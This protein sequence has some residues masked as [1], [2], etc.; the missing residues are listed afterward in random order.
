MQNP[1]L[2]IHFCSHALSYKN[3]LDEI[4]IKRK[5]NCTVFGGQLHL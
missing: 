3:V 5:H 1:F 2:K 4:S